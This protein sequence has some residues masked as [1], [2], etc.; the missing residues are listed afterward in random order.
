[1]SIGVHN[2][3]GVQDAGYGIWSNNSRRTANT[4]KSTFAEQVK[5]KKDMSLDEYK[6][7]FNEKMNGLYTHPSQKKM[8]WV[9]DITDSAYKRMQTDSAYE[10]KIMNAIATNKAVNFGE[11]IPVIAY[12]HVDDTWEDCYGYTKG[13]KE[14]TGYVSGLSSSSSK[15]DK[16]KKTEKKEQDFEVI[17]NKIEERKYL[18]EL[19]TKE[20][21]EYKDQTEKMNKRYFAAQAY[22]KQ[23]LEESIE[24]ANISIEK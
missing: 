2:N 8:N 18:Q 4:E 19:R 16:A 14:N 22:D 12:T 10:D 15:N 24:K 3:V 6:A 7:Y 11:N 21:L 1:M 9:I 13:M 20:Y 17:Q 5:S 23:I